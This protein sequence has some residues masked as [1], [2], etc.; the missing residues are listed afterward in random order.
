MAT[1]E[2]GA[3]LP[4]G[5]ASRRQALGKLLTNTRGRTPH[6]AA[7][8]SPCNFMLLQN[9]VQ[10][11]VTVVLALLDLLVTWERTRCSLGTGIFSTQWVL[12]KCQGSQE[13]P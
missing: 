10:T 9:L 13:D 11:G 5:R 4:L 7:G 8:K 3:N 1:E 6:R 12:N 2:M